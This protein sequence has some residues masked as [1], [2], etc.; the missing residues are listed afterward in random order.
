M[1]AAKDERRNRFAPATA[2]QRPYVVVP[3]WHDSLEPDCA[4]FVAV[5]ELL[6]LR[7]AGLASVLAPELNCCENLASNR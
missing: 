7:R 5:L 6:F 1:R 4:N 2:E 3:A